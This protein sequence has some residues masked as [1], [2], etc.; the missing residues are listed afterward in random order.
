MINIDYENEFRLKN[1]PE[2]K[3]KIILSSTMFNSQSTV[4]NIMKK[5]GDAHFVIVGSYGQSGV[6]VDT[7]GHVPVQLVEKSPLPV[8][9]V[10][11]SSFLETDYE[12]D[13][14]N[15][16]LVALDASSIATRCIDA[17]IMLMK[18]KDELKL[19]HVVDDASVN[20]N[21]ML[22]RHCERLNQAGVG[23]GSV[24]CRESD[25]F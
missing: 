13:S 15:H 17:A 23:V 7:V 10:P 20:V 5:A 11:P 8:I 1:V 2:S 19:V 4:T 21:E 16:Y 14:R 3:A 9:I 18:P 22:D 12:M 6:R 24:S 25:K